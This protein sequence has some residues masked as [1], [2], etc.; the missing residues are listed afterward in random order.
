M[1]GIL[2]EIV[3]WTFIVA[4]IA[5]LFLPILPGII[6]LLAGLVILS[7]RHHWAR[8]WITRLRERFPQADHHLRRFLNKHN[9]HIPGFDSTTGSE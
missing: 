4:G 2:L 5:G 6:F 9:R 8:R 3:G 7:T 1:K